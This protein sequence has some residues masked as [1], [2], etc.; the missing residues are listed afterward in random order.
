MN[1]ITRTIAAIL[2]TIAVVAGVFLAGAPATAAPVHLTNMPSVGGKLCAKWGTTEYYVHHWQAVPIMRIVNSDMVFHEF[3][4]RAFGFH[5]YKSVANTREEVRFARRFEKQ[6]FHAPKGDPNPATQPVIFC[7]TSPG[8]A[9]F[10]DLMFFWTESVPGLT[11]NERQHFAP[12]AHRYA[13]AH[14]C[15][16]FSPKSGA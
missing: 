1:R 5:M 10:L 16:V 3:N 14:G 7:R 12:W 11:H 2:T 6:S 9:Y 13:H 4:C 15:H 8:H